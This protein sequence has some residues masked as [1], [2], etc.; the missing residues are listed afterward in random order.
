MISF[1]IYDPQFGAVTWK[2]EPLKYCEN[3]RVPLFTGEVLGGNSR[4]NG[5]VYTRGSAA[6]YDAWAAI[7]RTD[8]SYEKVLPY[9]VKAQNSINRPQSNSCGNSGE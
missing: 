8:W 3:R 5:T 7:G 1:N 6:D 2:S 9:F 4:I